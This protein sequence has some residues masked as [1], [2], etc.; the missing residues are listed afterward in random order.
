[1]GGDMNIRIH[2]FAVFTAGFTFLLIV[3]GA[4]VTSTGSGLAVPDWPL[5]FGQYFP[6]M[7][8]GVFFEH[9]HRMIAG[10][11][12]ILTTVLAVWLWVKEKR[13][14]I[15]WLGTGA[16]LA[17]ITQAVLGGI[18]VLHKL[19]TIVS[20]SHAVLAQ[21]F[22]CSLIAVAFFTRPGSAEIDSGEN[23]ELLIRT[24]IFRWQL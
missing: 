5:S 12:G 13:R 24:R 3:A 7:T 15:C 22:F 18:T 20:A 1:M 6:E 9:G 14:W 16:W 8:G 19:P 17:V 4:L 11:V 2:R 10:T 21:I 23:R